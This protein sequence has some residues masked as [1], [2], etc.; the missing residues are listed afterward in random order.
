M[1]SK[2]RSSTALSRSILVES[3]TMIVVKK[4]ADAGCIGVGITAQNCRTVLGVFKSSPSDLS[5]GLC[6]LHNAL[7]TVIERLPTL[8]REAVEIY[9]KKKIGIIVEYRC[10]VIVYCILIVNQ[11]VSLPVTEFDFGIPKVEKRRGVCTVVHSKGRAVITESLKELKGIADSSPMSVALSLFR[12]S[13]LDELV[14]I[15]SK[16]P[17]NERETAYD[18]LQPIYPTESERLDKIKKG[19][20]NQ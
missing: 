20:E 19:S 3:A 11:G 10:E 8:G 5:Y 17:A 13:K 16:A 6:L 4:I 14:N 9:G 7:G 18:I 15:Y 12:D 1:Q 2:L